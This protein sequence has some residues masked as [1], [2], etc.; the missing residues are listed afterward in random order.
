MRCVGQAPSR[1]EVG[2]S[3]CTIWRDESVCRSGTTCIEGFCAE[4]CARDEFETCL[5]AGTVCTG[6]PQGKLC[7][8]PTFGTDGGTLLAPDAGAVA[9]PTS[10]PRP[11][12]GGTSVPGR[13]GAQGAGCS[14]G[15]LAWLQGLS[16]ASVTMRVLRKRRAHRSPPRN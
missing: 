3:G 9:P 13:V 14:C 11:L 7:L 12:D 2:P 10:G 16:A 4:P 1:C 8:P 5:P 15:S 6:L